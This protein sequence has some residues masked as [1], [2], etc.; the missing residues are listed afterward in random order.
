MRLSCLLIGATSA[1]AFVAPR[2]L[3]LTGSNNVQKT[4]TIQKLSLEDGQAVVDATT[5][6]VAAISVGFSPFIESL[7]PAAKAS[8]FL[9]SLDGLNKLIDSNYQ[10]D[11]NAVLSEFKGMLTETNL[12]ESEFA[13]YLSNLSHEIDQW[14]LTQNP[15]VES[16][17]NQILSQISSLK[18]D[19]PEVLVV[20]SFITYTIV[21]SILTWDQPPPP[22]KPYPLQRY[23]PIGAQVYFNDKPLQAISRGLEISLKSLRFA[24]SLL[25]DKIE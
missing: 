1:S 7:N 14:L 21:T 19:T 22:S 11:L 8:D 10:K 12:L 15:A 24:L 3:H 4:H 17:Y 6:K 2:P 16:L 25:K 23:D 9:Q 13:S 18:L 20:T 5:A